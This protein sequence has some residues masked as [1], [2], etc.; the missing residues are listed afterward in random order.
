MTHNGEVWVERTIRWN[1]GDLAL[2]SDE[3]R[4]SKKPGTDLIVVDGLMYV[5][6]EGGWVSIGSPK[7]IDPDS[8]TTPEEYLAAVRE[9]VGG[10]TLRRITNGMTGLTTRTLA[11]GSTVYSGAVAAGLIARETGFKEGEAIRVLPFGY[12]AHDRGGRPGQSAPD[13]GDRRPRGRRPRDRRQLGNVDVHG[14]VQQARRDSRPEGAGERSG[15][16]EGTQDPR[17]APQAI[18]L[19]TTGCPQSPRAAGSHGREGESLR[20]VG[21]EVRP[22]RSPARR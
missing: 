12:V 6:E 21:H 20:G 11:D 16:A 5:I 1:G 15:P 3:P 14:H 22:R 17:Q 4:R 19:K 10:R 18:T 7:S 9:D 8:G 13:G 2:S